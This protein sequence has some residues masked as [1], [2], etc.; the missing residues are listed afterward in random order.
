MSLEVVLLPGDYSGTEVVEA[1]VEVLDAVA[2]GKLAY[3][4][5]LLGGASIDAHG[6]ALTDETLEACRDADAVLLGAVGGPKWESDDPDAP[7]PE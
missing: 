7:R 3:K 5:R 4:E 1:A 6:V 2:K